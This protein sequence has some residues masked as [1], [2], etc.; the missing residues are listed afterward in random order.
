MK[1]N[2]VNLF[3][4]NDWANKKVLESFK[5][6]DQI[7]EKIQ[8]LFSHILISQ[9]IWLERLLLKPMSFNETMILL[10]LDE[11]R[12][13][14]PKSS[15]DWISFI[16]AAPE[17]NF[18]SVVSYKSTKGL[19]LQNKLS[20]IITHVINHSSYHRGQIALLVR[21]S[22]GVPAV[23]DYVVYCRK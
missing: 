4:Y 19:D 14:S 18:N 13:L 23:T 21:D 5:T 22:G 9:T 11:C 8:L 16:E 1:K 7:N 15:E 6:V 20:D 2:F 10:S 3:E 17:E 12:S